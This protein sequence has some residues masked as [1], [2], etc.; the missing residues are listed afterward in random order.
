M[1][2]HR[3]EFLQAVGGMVVGTLALRTLPAWGG[4]KSIEAVAFDA[5]TL[6]DG[7][8]VVAAAERLVPGQGAKLV[9]VWRNRLFEYSWLRAT[10]RRYLDFETV[11]AEA[12]AYSAAALR[13]PLNAEVRRT[14]LEATV[15]LPAWPEAASVLKELGA[16]GK[17][18][19]FLSNF[20]PRMLA[21]ALRSSGL[22]GLV[23]ALSTDSA[24]TYKPDP[25]AYQLAVDSFA[26]PRE[27]IAFVAHAGWDAV[28][29]AW[30]GFPTF[31]IDR[32]GTTREELAAPAY[33]TL[34]SLSPLPGLL[35]AGV[36]ERT[37]A[38]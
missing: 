1:R 36:E 6:L 18:L 2:R 11:S 5:F 20:T 30:F 3:R 8:P 22:E 24:Q 23:G 19:A 37:R 34:T 31:W 26:V 14:F 38:N 4:Q 27:R 15:R 33:T 35:A 7:R 10:G 12:L 16:S 17:K 9:E 13:L 21:S 25:R 28:G 29:A 32:T